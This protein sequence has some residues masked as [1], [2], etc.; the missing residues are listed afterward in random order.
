MPY[1]FEMNDYRP[2]AR[3]GGI[4]WTSVHVFEAASLADYPLGGVDIQ[5]IAIP[6]YPDAAAPPL[7]DFEVTQA[8]LISGWY[9]LEFRDAA[10]GRAPT[11][12]EGASGAGILIPPNSS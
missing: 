12:P 10:G 5:T 4:K 11:T 8:A 1:V 6:D 9:W 2:P 7:M 3:T